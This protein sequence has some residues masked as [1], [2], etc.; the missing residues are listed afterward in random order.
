VQWLRY[1]REEA[2]TLEEQRLD[3]LRQQRMKVLAA[4][5]DARWAGKESFLVAPVERR[6]G[7]LE[8]PD[9]ARV[10]QPVESVVEK[11]DHSPW[12]TA[13]KTKDEP[14]PWKPKTATRR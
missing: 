6:H 7:E 5:A 10:K 9:H 1:T 14:T 11:E 3:V 4:E 8:A 2:P 12:E 13:S